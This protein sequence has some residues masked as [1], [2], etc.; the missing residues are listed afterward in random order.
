[1]AQLA[2]APLLEQPLE[3]V[4]GPVEQCH[5]PQLVPESAHP[6]GFVR[7]GCG[8]GLGQLEQAF[9]LHQPL[10]DPKG[11]IAQ[12][13]HRPLVAQLA[14]YE[15]LV[16]AGCRQAFSLVALPLL[17]HQPL[18]NLDGPVTR[19]DS[20]PRIVRS[21]VVKCLAHAQIRQNRLQVSPA[22]ENQL[23]IDPA[24]FFTGCQI[25]DPLTPLRSPSGG[26]ETLDF[27]GVSSR[28]L[29]RAQQPLARI[30]P[31]ATN[32]QPPLQELVA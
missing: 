27:A 16:I 1:L 28:R 17:F 23:L 10:V 19:S 24:R 8:Q 18:V 20:S 3:E 14:H 26:Q 9:L 2:P 30:S 15:C 5:R 4:D 22:A 11:P 21:P 12:R 6:V 31:L 32:A 29:E 13:Y 7:A 25:R